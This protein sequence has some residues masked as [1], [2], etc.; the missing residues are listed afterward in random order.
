VSKAA[1]TKARRMGLRDLSQYAWRHQTTTMKD[2]KRKIFHFEHVVQVADL[3]D[4]IMALPKPTKSRITAL[5]KECQVAWIL[6]K[7]N[8]ELRLGK[9]LDPAKAYRAAGIKLVD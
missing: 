6:K 8:K 5:L 9:R 2:K 7:E 1:A 3:T 4:R